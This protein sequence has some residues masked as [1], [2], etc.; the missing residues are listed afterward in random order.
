[1]NRFWDHA[2]AGAES[3][4]DVREGALALR[5][6]SQQP[7]ELGEFDQ[8]V[9]C[10]RVKYSLPGDDDRRLRLHENFGSFSYVFGIGAAYGS[11]HRC[12]IQFPLEFFDGGVIGDLD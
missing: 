7:E 5:G 2:G 9:R 12:I 3:R 8:F 4:D 1:M 6:S 10:F 11:F